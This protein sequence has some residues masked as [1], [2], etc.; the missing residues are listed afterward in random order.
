M[1]QV[2]I[3]KGDILVTEVPSPIIN[4][5]EILVQVYYSCISPGTEIA[6]IKMSAKPLY[7]KV[8]EKP[9]NVKKVLDLIKEKGLKETISRIKNKFDVKNPVGYSA[10]GIVLE[11]GENIYS[12][13]PGDKVACAG[14]GIANHAEF[15]AVPQNL[16]VK[17]PENVS[18]KEAS[19]MTLGAIALQGLRR[20][21]LKLGETAVVIGLGILGQLSIQML[22]AAGI[23]TIGIDLNALRINK[24]LKYGLNIGINPGDVSI[25][26]E[27]I[28][29]T[30][31][32]GADVVIITAASSSENVINQSIQMCR[33]KGKV[34][35]VGDVALN[36]KR[37]ELYKKEIDLLISTSYGPG[38]YDDKY[39]KKGFEYPI[40]YVRWTENRNMEA[41]LDLIS[42]R[43]II[44]D[45][46]IDNI[47][48]IDEADKAYEDLKKGLEA[49]L[50]T[51]IEYNKENKPETK[52]FNAN[53]KVPDKDIND[54]INVA[55]IG[56]GNFTQEVHLP[57]LKKLSDFYNIYAICDKDP[58][59]A[60]NLAKKY[61][62]KYATTDYQEV[63]DDEKINM[64]IISTRHN[65]HAQLSIK[66]AEKGKAIL[67][68]KPMALSQQELDNLII[69]LKEYNT[70]FMVG[71]NRRF[72]PLSLAAKEITLKRI[73]PLIINYRMNAGYIP[74]EV[75]VH[76]EE[77]GGRNIGEACHIYDLFNYFT[78]SEIK[79]V[80]ASSIDPKS[81]NIMSND[82]FTA[83]LKYKDGSV[84]SL[85]YTAIGSK[86]LPK[87]L[88]DIYIDGKSLSLNDYKELLVFGISGRN[89]KLS[90]QDKGHFNELKL[91]AQFIKNKE[92]SDIGPIPLWQLNQAT[93]I[94]FEIEKQIRNF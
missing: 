26:E 55:V 52:I 81:E 60:D 93:V 12:F 14:A 31:G 40:A 38:R 24:A 46:I 11:V 91:F 80:S 92:K 82:N 94:S 19:T 35:I 69:A 53:L 75:W 36:I 84:C 77:G 21:D 83:L 3:K 64:V 78:Q 70:P 28:N 66:A 59:S 58:D 90:Y 15:I 33:K 10:S 41:Y 43:K 61:E 79:E 16:T 85:T 68:E 27:V 13:R 74:P 48:P 47:Y 63:F 45:N 29:N 39:E 86:E 22:K 5:D 87:E 2:F 25:V 18:F 4:D 1:K 34:V 57:N 73:N 56:A 67:V 42:D 65:L 54:K 8:I 71:F 7:K 9:Q 17:I 37:E 89:K 72:S 32:Y 23:K 76:T 49:P 88:M 51:L 6:G 50:V 44:L 30:N 20:A 62:A